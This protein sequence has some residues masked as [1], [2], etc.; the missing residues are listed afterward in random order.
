MDNAYDIGDAL[1][2]IE[3]ELIQSMINNL[4]RHKA[5]AVRIRMERKTNRKRN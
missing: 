5:L 4:K 3:D 1:G 2:R